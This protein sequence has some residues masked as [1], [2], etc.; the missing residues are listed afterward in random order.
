MSDIRVTRAMCGAE[1]GTDHRLIVSKV[2]MKVYQKRRPQGKALPK[3]L[4]INKLSKSALVQ[5]ALE[6]DLNVGLSKFPFSA[7]DIE[8]NWALFKDTIYET[9]SETIGFPSHRHQ[10]W[11]DENNSEI[12]DLIQKKRKLM[13][14]TAGDPTSQS[15]QDALRSCKG[16]LQKKLR[17]MKNDWFEDRVRETQKWA[18]TNNTHKFYQSLRCIYGPSRLG[19]SPLL[20]QD[21]MR[22]TDKGAILKRWAEHFESVLNRPSSINSES[23]DS[24]PQIPVDTSLDDLPTSA[25]TKSAIDV[26]SFNKAPGADSIPAEVFAFGGDHLV[27]TLTKLFRQMWESGNIPQ[28]FRDATIVHLYKN[29]GDRQSC[30]NHSYSR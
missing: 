1:C 23:I 27:E 14:S 20:D 29:K 19:T 21:G 25:E 12:Q 10:D 28:E 8:G 26:M 2:A 5:Q 13:Q 9:A 3:R 18:D 6:R 30:D 11:F 4:D 24:L 17:K 16:L 22:I 7:D 15:K